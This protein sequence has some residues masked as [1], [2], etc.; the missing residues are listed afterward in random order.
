VQALRMPAQ[1]QAKISAW[2]GRQPE[3]RPSRSEAM[4]RLIEKGLG[5][6]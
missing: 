4:R 3:P 1:L 5:K 6:E 2:I